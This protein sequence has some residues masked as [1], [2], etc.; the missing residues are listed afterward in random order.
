MK[1]R[2]KSIQ[3]GLPFKIELFGHVVSRY[4]DIVEKETHTRFSSKWVRGEWFKELDVPEV[5]LYMLRK[6]GELGDA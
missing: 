1:S 2:V 6:A 5:L 3:N 4:G